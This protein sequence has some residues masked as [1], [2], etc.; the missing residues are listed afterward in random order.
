MRPIITLYA[1]N[2][3]AQTSGVFNMINTDNL[4]PTGSSRMPNW[5]SGS[6]YVVGDQVISPITFLAYVR[7]TNGG[8]VT[9]PSSDG[10]N[11]TPLGMAIKQI[12]RGVYF[13]CGT[14]NIKYSNNLVCC[15]REKFNIFSWLFKLVWRQRRG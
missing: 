8:G 14:G 1:L 9:D 12:I 15:Y 13:N 11:W 2:P 4:I 7:K 3:T 10:T 6:S 5:A